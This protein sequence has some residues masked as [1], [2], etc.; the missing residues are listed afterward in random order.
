MA[1]AMKE[2]VYSALPMRVVFGAG[3]RG[4]ACERR[5]AARNRAYSNNG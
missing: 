1:P 3:A 2:F 5:A 4:C